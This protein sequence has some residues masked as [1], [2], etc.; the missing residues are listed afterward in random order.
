MFER[1]EGAQLNVVSVSGG[2][3]STATLAVALVTQPLG[4]IRLVFADTGFE[5]VET[6]AQVDALEG[7]TGIRVETVRA[8]LG[9]ALERK[10]AAL[11]RLW[12]R[13]GVPEERIER[14]RQALAPTGYPFLDL[15]LLKGRFPSTTARFCTEVLKVV[16]LGMYHEECAAQG[17]WVWS[18]Q[19]IRAEESSARA[20]LPAWEDEDGEVG[21]Y[22]PLMQWPAEATFEAA[23]AM[24]LPVNRLYS[25]GMNRVGC[26]PCIYARK[27]EIAEIARRWPERVEQL[28]EWEAWVGE[29]SRR[30][31][32]TFFHTFTHGGEDDV[33]SIWAQENVD[34]QVRWAGT[35][36][37]GVQMDIFKGRA[38]GREP[39]CR[40]QYGLCE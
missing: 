39:G 37:G 16:P 7:A 26:N 4:S 25:Q 3:D 10:R 21:V 13:Q 20:H 34:Q 9:P 31:R 38:A 12:G 23:R 29:A 36:R 35:V 1:G 17:W 15:A 32:T 24:G 2:K 19:G 6:L 18:W 40:A 8:D 27:Q 28:R 14:A 5:H 11:P 30:G 22:R 33:E